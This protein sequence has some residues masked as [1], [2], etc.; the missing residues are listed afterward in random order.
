MASRAIDITLIK[1]KGGA[2]LDPGVED[3]LRGQLPDRVVQ[4]II[5][6]RTPEGDL[7]SLTVPRKAFRE[8]ILAND[9]FRRTLRTLNI[10]VQDFYTKGGIGEPLDARHYV[11][12]TKAVGQSRGSAIPQP[13]KESI[14]SMQ[15]W[16]DSLGTVMKVGVLGLMIGLPLYA[17][18]RTAQFAAKVISEYADATAA[19]IKDEKG[20]ERAIQAR[21]GFKSQPQASDA[22][23]AKEVSPSKAGGTTKHAPEA[24]AAAPQQSE[25]ESAPK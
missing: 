9:D 14:R 5:S 1:S 15:E 23:P 16:L 24:S 22:G 11:A 17:A 25:P 13:L 8:A 2:S 4:E 20:L 21:S 12:D 6:T 18:F 7:Q 3:L 19:A 10:E